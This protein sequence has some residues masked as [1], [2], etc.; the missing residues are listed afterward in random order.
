MLFP[1]DAFGFDY[2]PDKINF[3]M[4]MVAARSNL[5][6]RGGGETN[7]GDVFLLRRDRVGPR[8]MSESDT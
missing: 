7:T 1:M 3:S 8:S 6:Q 2:A 4:G 5:G